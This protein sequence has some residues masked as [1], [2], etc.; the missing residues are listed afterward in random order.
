MVVLARLRMSVPSAEKSAKR[1]SMMEVHPTVYDAIFDAASKR[2][3]FPC[4]GTVRQDESTSF[5]A[6]MVM[7]WASNRTLEIHP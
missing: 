3:S 2:Q 7:I 4:R 6:D 5:S 1:T